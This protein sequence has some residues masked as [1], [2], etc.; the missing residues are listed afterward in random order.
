MTAFQK[1]HPP[2]MTEAGLAKLRAH[3]EA[4]TG[5]PRTA[6]VREKIGA[7]HRGRKHSPER[8]AIM[9][10]ARTGKKQSAACI[11]NRF[12]SRKG[13]THSPETIAK[14]AA[15]RAINKIGKVYKTD[16][17]HRARKTNEYKAWRD[18]VFSR[19][20]WTCQKCGCGGNLHPH[21]IRNCAEDLG[22]RYDPSNGVTLCVPHHKEFH[23]TFGVR[24]NTA[25]Q[26]AEFISA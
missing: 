10:K 14:M 11:A 2:Y 24:S 22:L 25:D 12:A 20:N 17:S 23:R 15:T 5:V 16:E 9:S 4:R 6:E 26:I 21:H 3:A 18:A 13:Y 1:G 8:S 19:D 7:A